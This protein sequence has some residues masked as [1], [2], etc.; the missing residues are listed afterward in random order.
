LFDPFFLRDY[1]LAAQEFP[2]VE[3]ASRRAFGPGPG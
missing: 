2:T 3:A 1:D